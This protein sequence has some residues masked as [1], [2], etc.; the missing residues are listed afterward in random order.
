MA[1][2]RANCGENVRGKT[3]LVFKENTILQKTAMSDC[4]GEARLGF[5]CAKLSRLT[6]SHEKIGQ[7]KQP[8]VR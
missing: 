7:C 4:R 1:I 8:E 5:V 3:I 6:H 2:N